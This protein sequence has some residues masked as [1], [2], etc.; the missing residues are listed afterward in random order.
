MNYETGVMRA[1]LNCH[2]MFYR[3]GCEIIIDELKQIVK[4]T[5]FGE[6]MPLN[7]REK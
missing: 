7:R 6:L 1:Y 4:H 2:A 5:S 3:K